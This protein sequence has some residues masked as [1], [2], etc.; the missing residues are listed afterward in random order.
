MEL[1]SPNNLGAQAAHAHRVPVHKPPD[2]TRI[3]ET[4]TSEKTGA[5]ARQKSQIAANSQTVNALTEQRQQQE[6]Q[7]KPAGPPPSFE[8]SLL[9][10]EQDLKQVLA[11]MEI[12][13]GQ[14]RDAE[15]VRTE[16]SNISTESAAEVKEGA[17]P[18]S[19]DGLPAQPVSPHL[20]VEL[21]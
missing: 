13:R 10:V 14:E 4:E 5:D 6:K 18:A 8:V 11:R 3:S 12:S 20:D 9:E 7:D 16:V 21:Q 19:T 2:I 17:A 1:F 15:A